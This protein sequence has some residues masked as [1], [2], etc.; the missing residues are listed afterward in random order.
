VKQ[1][2]GWNIK[3]NKAMKMKRSLNRLLNIAFIFIGF[4][5]N[6]QTKSCLFMGA[7][8]HLG[9]GKTIENGALGIKDGKI[10]LAADANRI[11]L[12][13]DAYDTIIN[14][15][16]KQIYP[17]FISLL[18]QLGLKEIDAVRATRDETEVGLLNPHIRA[19]TAYNT[20]SRIIPTVRSNGILTVQAT[21]QGTLLSGS[22]SIFKLAGW[23]WEDAALKLDDGIHLNWPESDGIKAKDDTS[24]GNIRRKK[25]LALLQDIFTD[26]KTYGQQTKINEKNI[27]LEAMRGL[28]DGSKILYIEANKARDIS[29]SLLF[30]SQHGVKKCVITGA[31]EVL[32]VQDNVKKY[33]LGVILSMLH[34]LPENPDDAVDLVFKTPALLTQNGI[35]VALGYTGEKGAMGSRNLGFLA[36]TA[37][38]YGLEK[39]VALQLI[40]S[41]A[42]LLCGIQEQ[43]GTLENGKNATFFIT[44]G[45]ALDMRSAKVLNA[46]IDGIEIDLDNPQKQLYQKYSKK[47]EGLK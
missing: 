16:G 28:F 2:N 45:D 46:W 15:Q 47:Y 18:S 17:G 7:T 22:S 42:A 21:P 31:A 40:T 6:A 41:N 19:L 24:K 12:S 13:S 30:A 9:N 32:M 8:L 36:G 10:V 14:V 44:Q 20:D 25:H 37:A 4:T 33:A 35:P 3:I 11:K 43:L 34:K 29:E 5:A 26:A 38:A 1:T 27:K 39:E 23:N